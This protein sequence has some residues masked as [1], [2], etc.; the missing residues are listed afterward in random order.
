MWFRKSI[1]P[2]SVDMVVGWN[3]TEQTELDFHLGFG[4]LS[5]M[6]LCSTEMSFGHTS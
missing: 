3:V 2:C 1:F 6:V 4:P 5:T